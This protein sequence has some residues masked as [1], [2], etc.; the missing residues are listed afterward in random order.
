MRNIDEQLDKIQQ[1][2]VNRQEDLKAGRI[3]VVR[4]QSEHPSDPEKQT[5]RVVPPAR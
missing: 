5:A 2:Q 1:K 4:P 3:R